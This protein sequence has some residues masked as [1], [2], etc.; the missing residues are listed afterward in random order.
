MCVFFK[1]FVVRTVTLKFRI[2]FLYPLS[3]NKTNTSFTPAKHSC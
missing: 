2:K 1:L 3:I